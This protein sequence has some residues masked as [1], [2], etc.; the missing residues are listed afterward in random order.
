MYEYPAVYEGNEP[1]A[2]IS[3][4]HKDTEEVLP[5]V[6]DLIEN[7]YRVWYD[8]GINSGDKF[9]KVIASHL[10]QSTCMIVFLSENSCASEYCRDEILYGKN[11]RIPTLVAYLSEDF[12]VPEDIDFAL[13]QAHAIFRN[14]YVDNRA[15]LME[16]TKPEVLQKCKQNNPLTDADSQELS[17]A[18]EAYRA[19]VSVLEASTEK[20][21][22]KYKER[23]AK[24]YYKLG[25][26]YGTC[27]EMEKS[28]FAYCQY[29]SL[30]EQ[31]DVSQHKLARE[32]ESIGNF[33][34]RNKRYDY[35]AALYERAVYAYEKCASEDADTYEHRLMSCV[36]DLGEIYAE[37]GMRVK[38]VKQYER[39][40][41]ICKRLCAK[42]PKKYQ[43]AYRYLCRLLGMPSG[44]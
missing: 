2:F 8:N 39:A 15:F 41:D 44:S 30:R 31:L 19:S 12:T 10:S 34:R 7:G 11:K 23:L 26:F 18:E 29:L 21:P 1:Y 28:Y 25:E 33:Y 22:V 24:G 5:L 6:R 27:C 20:N 4:A 36:T 37:Y 9:V 32:Y 17:M 40:L 14:R 16:L 42:D 35:A 3:Y 38:A 43:M 13:V